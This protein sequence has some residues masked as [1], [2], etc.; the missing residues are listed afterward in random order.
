MWLLA[1]V[2]VEGADDLAQAT[3]VQS[4]ILL[5]PAPELSVRSAPIPAFPE[6]LGETQ[7][8]EQFL[9]VARAVL[10]RMPRS[11]INSRR[12]RGLLDVTLSPSELG[13]AIEELKPR[14]L[15]GNEH[16][17]ASGSSWSVSGHKIGRFGDNDLLRA[18][19]ALTGFGALIDNEAM[20]FGARTDS[21]ERALNGNNVY[22]WQV[23][24]QGIPTNAFW[25]LS[26]YEIDGS[27][28][29]FFTPNPINRYAIGNRTRGL[30][31]SNGAIDI[32]VSHQPPDDGDTR[33]WLPAPAGPFQL[34]L[35]AY[36]PKPKMLARQ[37]L[38][39]P[40]VRL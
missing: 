7:S 18:R 23:P 12:S 34:T 33:N 36:L 6:V 35:R 39:P 4:A 5:R 31:L 32:V 11:H 21:L 8:G 1:R 14:L 38:P 30:S 22:R 28:R 13:Q 2:L 10:G 20:Y 29:L 27:G 25:S 17:T 40:L 26:L 9:Q 19:T 16:Q 3:S 15:I 37:W 24:A